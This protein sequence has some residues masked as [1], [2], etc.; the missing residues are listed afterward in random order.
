MPRIWLVGSVRMN[1]KGG[2]RRMMSIWNCLISQWDIINEIVFSLNLPICIEQLWVNHFRKWTLILQL[3]HLQ[4]AHV[5]SLSHTSDSPLH[6]IS[7]LKFIPHS[8]SNCAKIAKCSL[9]WNLIFHYNWGS[10]ELNDFNHFS[11]KIL[12][13]I[14]F[15]ITGLQSSC[16]YSQSPQNSLFQVLVKCYWMIVLLMKENWS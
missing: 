1:K 10:R 15:S 5:D 7:L 6:E 9:L 12:E 2:K 11:H 4:N 3:A 13:Y 8:I 14:S 16:W